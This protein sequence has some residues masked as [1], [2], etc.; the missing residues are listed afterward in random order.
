MACDHDH[1]GLNMN[2][3]QGQAQW[4]LVCLENLNAGG[5]DYKKEEI[6]PRTS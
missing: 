3:C 2:V 1:C 5:K 6:N 4:L